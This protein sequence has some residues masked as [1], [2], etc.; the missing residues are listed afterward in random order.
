M[1]Q[2]F[3]YGLKTKRLNVIKKQIAFTFQKNFPEATNMVDPV[4]QL[5]ARLA[6]NRK[7][8][9]FYEDLPE[10]TTIELLKEISR[11]IPASSNILISGL[12][13]EKGV[14]SLK[15]EAKTIDDVTSI[16]NEL[17]KSKYFKEVTMGSTSLTK[18]GG[19]VEFN[20]RIEV[21]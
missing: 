1:S 21:K 2:L 13:Y 16:K 9:D 14:I 5:K 15:G 19:K 12:T 10:T 6:E 20:L 3:D 8:F 4:Q 17:L 18:D 7:T 11:L